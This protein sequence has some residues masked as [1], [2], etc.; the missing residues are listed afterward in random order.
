M[1]CIPHT[2]TEIRQSLGL[3]VAEASKRLSVSQ[4]HTWKMI[5]N[6]ELRVVRFGR[7]TIVPLIEIARILG[8]G[9]S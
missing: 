2:D 9:A 6:G 1:S 5:R 4:S 8:G 7:R 3:S